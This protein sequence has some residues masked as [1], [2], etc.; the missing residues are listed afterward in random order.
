MPCSKTITGNL[1]LCAVLGVILAFAA[2]T[3]ADG[4]DLLLEVLHPGVIG[5]FVIPLLGAL[6]DA[7]IILVSGI[8]SQEQVREE[9][10][11]GMGTL[12]GSTIMLLTIA[13]TGGLLAGRTDIV[14]G[15]SV[16]HRLTHKWN[17]LHTGV[18]TM[19]DIRVN[20]VIMVVTLLPYFVIQIVSF[21]DFPQ[22]IDPV[23]K[24]DREDEFV[25]ASFV[26]TC[27][28]FVLYSV[29]MVFNTTM[30]E[31]RIK[32]ARRRLVIQKVAELF[33]QSMGVDPDDAALH[34]RHLQMADDDQLTKSLLRA[35]NDPESADSVNV[36]LLTDQIMNADNFGTLYYS[37][38]KWKK[39]ARNAVTFHMHAMEKAEAAAAGIEDDKEAKDK[40]A[41]EYAQSMASLKSMGADAALLAIQAEEKEDDDDDDDDDK[42]GD[43]DEKKEGDG[44]AVPTKPG[45]KKAKIILKACIL[46]ALGAGAASVFSDPMVDSITGLSEAIHI[47][48]FYIS[49]ILTPF[50][51]NASELIASLYFCAKKTSK[52]VSVAM[53]AVYGAVT[54][55]STLNLG[56]FLILMWTRDIYWGFSAEALP[57]ILTVFAVGVL[58]ALKTT[59]TTLEGI[60]VFF[61]YPLSLG[62]TVLLRYFGLDGNK[63]PSSSSSLSSSK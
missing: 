23:E 37:V 35:A 62:L 14:R 31:R 15:V 21:V 61:L 20:A 39:K 52:S 2:K 55:N 18:T 48:P 59:F 51:S 60:L 43:D 41:S 58:G 16:D 46:L 47:P 32:A 34:P 40:I 8:G 4:S 36:T 30:Q 12:C 45:A 29:Y 19:S 56:I 44:K 38:S 33:A 24:E 7:L 63:F 6:P 3:I 57:M 5:G 17:I 22:I 10:Y 26:I 49:F 27:L 42:D 9:I 1:F 28:F 11:V 50:A 25:M 54:M 53:A 13:W